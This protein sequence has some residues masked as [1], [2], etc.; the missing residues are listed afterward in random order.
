VRI[1]KSLAPIIILLIGSLYLYQKYQQ[2]PLSISIGFAYLPHLLAIM[3]LGL[4]V[5]FSRS[6]IFFYTL[7]IIIT[8][9]VIRFDWTSEQGLAYSMLATFVPLLF[10]GLALIPDRGIFNIK[11]LPSYALIIAALLFSVYVIKASPDWMSLILLS[12]WLPAKYFDWTPLPQTALLMSILALFQLMVL[13]ILQ[14]SPHLAAGFGV[15]ILLILQIHFGN[16]VPALNV[17]SGVALLMCLYAVMQESWR[18]A[19]L[20]ELT[21]LPAR[22]ALKEKFSNMGGRYTIAMLDVDHFKKFNDTYGHDIGDAVLRMI[23]AKMMRVTGGGS[24]YRYGGEEFSIVFPGQNTDGAWHH[25]EELRLAIANS[26]FVINRAERRKNGPVKSQTPEAVRVTVS[27]GIA[28]SK[29]KPDSPW[30][31][32]KQADQALYRAKGKGRNCV[33]E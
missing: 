23:A 8:N 32:L 3:V 6:A 27:I 10:L 15:L 19:Y 11:A 25:L 9:I 33:C 13:C 22:R 16:Q 14:P 31:V 30:V 4:S 7:Q 21:G 26:K 12:D 28:D 5:H 2:I 29:A 18:M 24:S 1:L 17:F 20:D